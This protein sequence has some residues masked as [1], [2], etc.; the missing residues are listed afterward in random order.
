MRE[1]KVSYV[2][3]KIK[4][5]KSI[6]LENPKSMV[7]GAM[8]FISGYQVDKQCEGVSYRGDL[9]HLIELGEGVT[10][11]P[12]TVNKQSCELGDDESNR[13]GM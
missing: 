12:Q 5:K 8:Q 13:A 4:G 7:K 11:L 3:V 2:K 6:Y 10:V 9:L 1:V